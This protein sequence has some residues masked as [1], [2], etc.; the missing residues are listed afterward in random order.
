MTTQYKDY[1]AYNTAN[2]FYCSAESDKEAI[3][4]TRSNLDGRY[5]LYRLDIV[6]GKEVKVLI[7]VRKS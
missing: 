1:K 7:K 5:R 2:P 4:K 6:D 3:K